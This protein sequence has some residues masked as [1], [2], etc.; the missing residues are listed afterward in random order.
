M[1]FTPLFKLQRPIL[2]RNAGY[3]QCAKNVSIIFWSSIKPIFVVFWKSMSITTTTIV[4]TRVSINNSPIQDPDIIQMDLSEDTTSWEASSTITIGNHI[5]LLEASDIVFV[6]YRLIFK[7]ISILCKAFQPI[8]P[9]IPR[10]APLRPPVSPTDYDFTIP[11]KDAWSKSCLLLSS[12]YC[13]F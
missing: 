5:L 1:L 6:P 4:L 8:I 3:V 10:N 12:M 2:S 7:A 13:S 9:I 11:W